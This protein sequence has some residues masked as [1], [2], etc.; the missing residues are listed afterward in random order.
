[1]TPNEVQK[2][3]ELR[4]KKW[5]KKATTTKSSQKNIIKNA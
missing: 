5:G 3:L 4:V 2:R 1:M